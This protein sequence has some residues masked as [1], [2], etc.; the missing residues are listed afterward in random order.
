MRF[1]DINMI[2]LIWVIPFMVAVF[3]YGA[4]RRRRLMSGFARLPGRD[5]ISPL[6]TTRMRIMRAIVIVSAMVL[7]ILA[8]AGP[9]Y[10]YSW[11]QIERK[12]IDI[13]I[14]LD[15][16]KSMM[17][18]DIK[19]NR[20]D[21][22]KREVYDLLTM[23]KGDRVG[24]VAFSGTAFLQCP[25]TLDYDAYNLF[26]Q[27]LTPD[28]L[29]VGGSDLDSAVR[30]AV[31]GFDPDAHSEKA[32]ILITDGEHTGKNDLLKTAE[33]AKNAGIKLF[34]I[35]VG[36]IEGVPI[37]S[38]AGGFKKDRTGQIV[39][40][41]LD[42][43][44]LKQMA[45]LTGGAYVR[46]VA[47]DMDLDIIY[48]K[49]I[50]G[51]M[52][53]GT[54]HTSRKKIWENRY[55][56]LLAI[57]MFLAIV[58][59][60]LPSASLRTPSG[61]G[62]F[63]LFCLVW[64]A[65]LTAHADTV[66]DAVTAYETADYEA[67]LKGFIKS[68]LDDPENPDLLFNIGNS[69]YKTGNFDAA[70]DHYNQALQTA[71]SDQALKQKTLYNLG[72]SSFRKGDLQAA[73]QQYEAALNIDPTDE[74]AQQNLAYVKKLMAQQK[75]DQQQQQD[76]QE[77]GD[78]QDKGQDQAGSSGDEQ[79]EGEPGT[80]SGKDAQPQENGESPDEKPDQN[81]QTEYGSEMQDPGSGTA[82]EQPSEDG[83]TSGETTAGDPSPPGTPDRQTTDKMLNRLED[84]PGRAMIPAYQQ[85]TV[86]KDW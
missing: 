26:L 28:F 34:C 11:Q 24:L 52:E 30:T 36:S 42:E 45:A 10:G 67:A 81:S 86:E 51:T 75:Q 40:S 22:A 9:Q 13:I 64:A 6:N 49:Q 54:L 29:P 23:L 27:T 39:L 83:P 1:A 78:R 85:Q 63:L 56:W 69:Y 31:D 38:G 57:A 50:R 15:V 55:Q 43:Q 44:T 17:A 46:S 48:E 41:R 84:Q 35:G 32:I 65:P 66:R 47:G 4:R 2:Y 53:A 82:P 20:L 80:E 74:N 71:D 79:N 12:G 61:V 76:N 33:A 16:S 62:A 21:G 19:P 68:Q 70:S 5:I 72:N 37:P 3:V 73:V 77:K 25:L 7:L 60:L 59:M 58:E 14:A 8:M 18:Q